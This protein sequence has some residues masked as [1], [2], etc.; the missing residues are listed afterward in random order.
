MSASIFGTNVRA[1]HE[2]LDGIGGGHP[3]WCIG[4]LSGVLVSATPS[5]AASFSCDTIRDLVDDDTVYG[6][7]SN[8]ARQE[9]DAQACGVSSGRSQSYMLDAVFYA[10]KVPAGSRSTC[11]LFAGM[12]GGG[13]KIRTIWRAIS[14]A[15][16]PTVTERFT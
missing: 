16:L 5:L 12:L 2:T 7:R 11:L 4:G 6:E 15:G 9:F 10:A 3:T 1:F 14:G 13:T 8:L